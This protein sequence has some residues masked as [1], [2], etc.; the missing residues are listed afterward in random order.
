MR[1]PW[2]AE[3]V[4]VCGMAASARLDLANVTYVDTA[5]V[6]LLRELMARGF[7]IVASSPFV[8]ALL[9]LEKA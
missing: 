5:G 7:E 9:Q 2:V 3:L 4:S 6:A 1:E 8:A